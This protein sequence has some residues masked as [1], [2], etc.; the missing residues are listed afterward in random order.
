MRWAWQ[1]RQ[2]AGRCG[3]G[4]SY[5]EGGTQCGQKTVQL[6]VGSKLWSEGAS[7]FN[8]GGKN[9]MHQGSWG[10]GAGDRNGMLG[11]EETWAQEGRGD[12]RQGPG[13]GT[14]CVVGGQ[15]GLR[16]SYGIIALRGAEQAFARG[17]TRVTKPWGSGLSVFLSV[18]LAWVLARG[19]LCF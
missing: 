2:Q 6:G 18:S 7:K 3:L 4:P 14:G 1:R 8:V 16:A 12:Q 13:V 19:A 9:A 15:P 17:L 10:W 5:K 11:A